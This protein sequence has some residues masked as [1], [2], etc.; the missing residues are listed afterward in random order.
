VTGC[1]AA[2]GDRCLVIALLFLFHLVLVASWRSLLASRSRSRPRAAVLRCV[3]RFRVGDRCIGGTT[4]H[5]PGRAVVAI[6]DAVAHPWSAQRTALL[7]RSQRLRRNG[8][9]LDKLMVEMQVA[10][11]SGCGRAG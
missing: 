11:C 3:P 9:C 1:V 7:P 10:R 2:P 4:G 8:T 5:A 6:L